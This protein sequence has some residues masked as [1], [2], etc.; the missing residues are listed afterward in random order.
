MYL[1]LVIDQE[2]YLTLCLNV[3]HSQDVMRKGKQ[4]VTEGN[5]N[6]IFQ[7]GD[8]RMSEDREF[9]F[10]NQKVL[11]AQKDVL[12]YIVSKFCKNLIGGKSIVNMSMPVDI[13]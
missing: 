9:V 7:N 3:K 10:Q 4:H 1:K 13:F 2:Q 11:D 5:N 6:F 8:W 12:R